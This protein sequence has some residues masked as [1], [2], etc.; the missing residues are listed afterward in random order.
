LKRAPFVALVEPDKSLVLL[1][2][3]RIEQGEA[4]RGHIFLCGELLEFFEQRSGLAFLTCYRIDV[5]EISL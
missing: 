5:A 4:G 3:A 2:Q 1:T